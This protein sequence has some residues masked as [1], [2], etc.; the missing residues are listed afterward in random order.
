MKIK[1]TKIATSVAL[2]LCIPA[3][4]AVAAEIITTLPGTTNIQRETTQQQYY[5]NIASR[6]HQIDA[7]L[8]SHNEIYSAIVG[9]SSFVTAFLVSQELNKD[10]QVVEVLF[11]GFSA[12]HVVKAVFSDKEWEHLISAE[13]IQE[14]N[15]VG[16][17]TF[18]V[19]PLW[20]LEVTALAYDPISKRLVIGYGDKTTRDATYGLSLGSKIE[21]K[22]PSSWFAIDFENLYSETHVTRGGGIRIY[23]YFD[24]NKDGKPDGYMN[25]SANQELQNA[26]NKTSVQGLYPFT[27]SNGQTFLFAAWGPNRVPQTYTFGVSVIPTPKPI[28]IPFISGGDKPNPTNPTIKLFDMRLSFN[29]VQNKFENVTYMASISIANGLKPG[30]V[31]SAAVLGKHMHDALI[32]GYTDGSI[33]AYNVIGGSEGNGSFEKIN[34][35]ADSPIVHMLYSEIGDREYLLVAH[36]NF[37]LDSIDYSSKEQNAAKKAFAE[38]T[39]NYK[40]DLVGKEL[41][42]TVTQSS[43]SQDGK[44]ALL[45]L[46]HQS[47]QWYSFEKKALTPQVVGVVT[48]TPAIATMTSPVETKTK[49]I[50]R[51]Y[52]S[53]VN[54][55]VK[56]GEYNVIAGTPVYFKDV[57]TRANIPLDVHFGHGH[58]KDQTLRDKITINP[59]LIPSVDVFDIFETVGDK[60]GIGFLGFGNKK[61]YHYDKLDYDQTTDT[62]YA[63]TLALTGKI[64]NPSWSLWNIGKDRLTDARIGMGIDTY[65]A[66]TK[67]WKTLQ[68]PKFNFMDPTQVKASDYRELTLPY[69]H[70]QLP[71]D[72]KK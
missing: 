15:L 42:T 33:D 68:K 38:H 11:L 25:F 39:V 45:A 27:S 19:D 6:G 14:N 34:A 50:Y 40:S 10:N 26:E 2:Y 22:K 8:R 63:Y 72:G 17:N 54:G 47:I 9:E 53:Y 31:P 44:Y 52:V 1:L 30:V 49:G 43:V 48:G 37:T 21:L 56:E 46:S 70:N 18:T 28:P 13:L 41:G 65:N 7:A 35:S 55:V 57:T 32:Y 5:K 69:P 64:A 59:A 4:Y 58:H 61:Y 66:K 71:Q 3:S 23:N 62:L 12:G 29:E 67:E 60:T 51:F 16:S 36:A 24:T 20:Q